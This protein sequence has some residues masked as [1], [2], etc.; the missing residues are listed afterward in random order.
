MS[1]PPPKPAPA[2]PA[3]DGLPPG[4][5]PAEVAAHVARQ[6]RL[7]TAAADALPGP[8]ALAFARAPQTVAGL[9]VRPVVHADFVVLK[10][11]GSPI[12]ANLMGKTPKRAAVHALSD[13]STYELIYQFTRPCAE[14]ER[15]VDSL[16]PK[17]FRDTA[18]QAIGYALGPIEVMLLSQAVQR[19]FEAAFS[20]VITHEPK[21]ADDG[22]FPAP[23]ARGTASA[24][25]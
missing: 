4:I 13:D 3:G 21:P 20:T 14:A 10:K 2:D 8:L 5:S 9:T 12:L 23:P 15:L 11:L 1:K 6:E 16:G 22:S 19:E 24:G 25:G 7:E 17:K 18:R